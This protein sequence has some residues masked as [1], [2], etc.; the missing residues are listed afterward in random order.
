[1]P[2]DPQARK[3]VEE[4]EQLG[5]PIEELTPAQARESM[6]QVQL[7]LF[8]KNSPIP[9][10][11]DVRDM[12]FT[13]PRGSINLRVFSPTPEN[14]GSRPI[15]VYLHG[16]GWVMGSIEIYDSLCRRICERSQSIVI[17]VDYRLAP[18]NKF[19][20]PLED[21]YAA[22]KW[23]AE[24]A[25]AIGGNSHLAVCGDSAGGNLAT[26]VALVSRDRG[27]P[28]LDCQILLCPG[29]DYRFDLISNQECGRGYGLTTEEEIWSWNN[30]LRD[31][32]DAD[33]PYACPMRASSLKDLAR[34]FIVTA[35]YDPLRDDGELYGKKLIDA[36]VKT[37]IS[38]YP[39]MIHGFYLT[40]GLIDLGDEA[41]DDIATELKGVFRS[42]SDARENIR[43]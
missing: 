16:G 11:L 8:D 24:N 17:A 28:K 3:V 2:L 29:T 5:P 36:G 18:E 41:I 20:I 39:G 34:A 38:R 26:A 37:K 15:V 14:E 13:G 25:S 19:P 12:N 4:M 35:E 23:I 7:E 6:R 21:C 30:Y 32:E 33:N 31:P 22:T 40:P 10:N 9:Q 27:G 1:M 43:K 42:S